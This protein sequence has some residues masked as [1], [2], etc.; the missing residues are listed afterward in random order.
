MLELAERRPAR[1]N[2]ADVRVAFAAL[3]DDVPALA[4]PAS[5]DPVGDDDLERLIEFTVGRPDLFAHLDPAAA[6]H[7]RDRLVDLGRA[8]D[9]QRR[10]RQVPTTVDRALEFATGE[11]LRRGFER[12]MAFRLDHG[13]LHVASTEFIT[14]AAWAEENH[15]NASAHPVPCEREL[16]EAVVIGAQVPALVHRPLDDPRVWTP[17]V[18]RM[19][20]DDYVVAPVVLDGRTVG[21]IHADCYFSGAPLRTEHRDTIGDLAAEL[22]THLRS[23]RS[24]GTVELSA[25]EAEVYDGIRRGLSNREIAAEL[26]VGV[27]TVKT[28]VRRILTKLDVPNRAAAAALA[29]TPRRP[30]TDSSPSGGRP[31]PR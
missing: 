8:L 14:R 12:A 22:S 20:C 24:V 9:R 19:R 28:H 21:T 10:L 25:R 3:T 29:V 6:A 26:V 31:S 7:R 16:L 11:L 1:H 5:A 27:E 17:I 15:R 13:A 4:V 18:G 2:D 23:T 30:T